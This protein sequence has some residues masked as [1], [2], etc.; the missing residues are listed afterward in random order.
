MA[1]FN[2]TSGLLFVEG[3]NRI[4]TYIK[5]G[6]LIN[7]KNI[8]DIKFLEAFEND[9]IKYY[10]VKVFYNRIETERHLLITEDE[11]LEIQRLIGG[12]RWFL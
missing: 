1:K 3:T 10:D 5:M 11:Y 2:P 7:T 6:V 9:G 4:R 8:W 12:R